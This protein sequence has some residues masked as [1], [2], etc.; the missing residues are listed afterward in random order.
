MADGF[1]LAELVDMGADF[2][3]G[4]AE[5][6]VEEVEQAERCDGSGLEFVLHGEELDAVAGGEDHG[7]ADAGLVREGA[8]GVG[9]AGDGNGETLTHVNGSGGVVDTEEQERA[10]L[11]GEV[12]HGALNLWTTERALADQTASTTRKTKLER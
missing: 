12:A 4:E 5:V 11:E 3:G 2:R 6:V 1:L 7:F 8:R 10:G 9:E